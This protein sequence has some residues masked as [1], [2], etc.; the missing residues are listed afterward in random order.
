MLSGPKL[1]AIVAFQGCV[2]LCMNAMVPLV[3]WATGGVE[4]VVQCLGALGNRCCGAGLPERPFGLQRTMREGCEQGGCVFLVSS[5]G[6]GATA[7]ICTT[8]V[9]QFVFGL[10]SKGEVWACMCVCVLLLGG[11][12]GHPVLLSGL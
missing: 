12:G 7:S 3:S 2:V 5:L 1:S 9:S 8:A 6:A 10:K 4:I 11:P